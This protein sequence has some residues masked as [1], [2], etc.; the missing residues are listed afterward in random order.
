MKT[1]IHRIRRP[2]PTA[3]DSINALDLG[4]PEAASSG[5]Q[6]AV[7]LPPELPL[8]FLISHV[9]PDGP[10]RLDG[11][12]LSVTEVMGLELDEAKLGAFAGA[13]TPAISRCSSSSANTRL[14]SDGYDAS[15]KWLS[16]LSYP[17]RREQRPSHRA[18]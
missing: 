12:K 11:V 16:R 1:L 18:G 4:E 17:L 8:C 6:P 2:P 3:A 15:L 13:L 7:K 5:D 10:V 9:E 14:I